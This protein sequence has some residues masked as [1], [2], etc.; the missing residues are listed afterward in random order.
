[1]NGNSLTPKKLNGN[2]VIRKSRPER[3]AYY[4]NI[5]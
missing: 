2:D 5:S 3:E 4:E 1:M